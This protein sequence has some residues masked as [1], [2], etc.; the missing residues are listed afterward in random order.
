MLPKASK[1][2]RLPVIPKLSPNVGDV[3]VFA[4]AAEGWLLI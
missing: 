4:R 3:T 1:A 2:T